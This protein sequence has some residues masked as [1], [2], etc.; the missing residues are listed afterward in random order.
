MNAKENALALVIFSL[1]LTKE[2]G[3]WQNL[4]SENYHFLGNKVL[5]I[6]ITVLVLELGI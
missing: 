2:H 3:P 5:L 6:L 1:P 4:F